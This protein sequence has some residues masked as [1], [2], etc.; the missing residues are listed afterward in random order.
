[1]NDGSLATFWLS[2][3]PLSGV[4]VVIDLQ[5]VYQV[6]FV[7]TQFYSPLPLQM[8]IERSTGAPN[9]STTWSPWQ[10]FASD[11]ALWS[12]SNNGPLVN[13]TTVNCQQYTS[14]NYTGSLVIFSVLSSARPGASALSSGSNTNDSALY[15]FTLARSVRITMKSRYFLPMDSRHLYYAISEVSIYARCDCNGKASSCNTTTSPYKCNC[16]AQSF[17]T[18][19]HVSDLA[20]K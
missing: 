15:D 18:G 3:F 5:D 4:S 16:D 19:N 12:M 13:S 20:I 2:S 14:A 17:T 11:C 1:M 9:S 8:V 6:L 7:Y 10:Y